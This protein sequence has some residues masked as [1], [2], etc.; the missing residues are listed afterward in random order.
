V[1]LGLHFAAGSGRDSLGWFTDQRYPLPADLAPGAS[2]IL[3]ATASAPPTASATVVEARLVKE[4]QFWF[5][6]WAALGVTVAPA[7]WSATYDVSGV[8]GSWAANQ[9]QTFPVTVTNTGNQTWPAGGSNPVHLGLHFAA[10]SG[11]DSLGWFTDQRYPLPA[12]LAPGASVILTVTASAPPTPS[13]TVVEARLVKEWQFWFGQWAALGV[14]W[15][16][17]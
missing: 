10:G 9:A 3:T 2:V 7:R 15:H 13:A 5:G 1:H 12:D 4:W 16:G 11:R 6:Q 14:T 17:S 8:P